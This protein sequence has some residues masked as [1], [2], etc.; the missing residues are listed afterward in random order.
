MPKVIQKTI[1]FINTVTEVLPLLEAI[2]GWMRRLKYPQGSEEWVR[3]YFSTMPDLNKAINAEA[4]KLS[5]EMNTDCTI[6]VAT[7]AYGMGIDNPDIK[8]VIQWDLPMS[9]DSMIQRMGRAGRQAGQ[10][11]VFILMT[12]KWTQVKDEKELQDWIAA[13]TDA[14]N[15]SSLFLDLNRLKIKGW[16]PSPL[17]CETNAEGS[18][19]TKSLASSD[20]DED[21]ND[22][23]T[24]KL[25]ALFI[26]EAE[27]KSLAKKAK[28]KE[29]GH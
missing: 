13:R 4:F 28:K 9:F 22:S 23:G 15:A 24:N 20:V 19:D 29:I 14:A 26:T 11:A 3:P 18:S 21:F 12:P 16:R 10:Q 2:R 17:S 7:D 5:G 8:L 27:E 1:I 25:F 6:F